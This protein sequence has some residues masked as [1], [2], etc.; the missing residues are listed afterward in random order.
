MYFALYTY[1]YIFVISI[2]IST[3]LSL[4]IWGTPQI[5]AGGLCTNPGRIGLVNLV[6]SDYPRS[7]WL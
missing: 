2:L 3:I 7:I 4:S 5:G 6:K 1:L